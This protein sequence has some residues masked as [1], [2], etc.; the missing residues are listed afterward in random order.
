MKFFTKLA[1]RLSGNSNSMLMF[2]YE[3]LKQLYDDLRS[4]GKEATDDI[5]SAARYSDL[6]K[7]FTPELRERWSNYIKT[8]RVL[9]G[10]CFLI[11]GWSILEQAWLTLVQGLIMT[12][13]VW[14]CLGY[15]IYVLR[16]KSYPPFIQYLKVVRKKLSSSLPINTAHLMD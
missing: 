1:N 12:G 5:A 6:R 4:G 13:F 9:W 8:V 2:G 10:L 16:E 14:V 11:V 3:R 7:T 15:R